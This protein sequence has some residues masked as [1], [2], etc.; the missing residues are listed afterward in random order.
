MAPRRRKFLPAVLVLLTVSLAVASACTRQSDPEPTA[1]AIRSESI[2]V[3]RTPRV[4][5]VSEQTVLWITDTEDLLID[6]SDAETSHPFT[7]AGRTV[8]FPNADGTLAPVLS[9]DRSVLAIPVR[10][11]D[12]SLGVNLV[13][14]DGYNM[15]LHVIGNE[16]LSITSIKFMLEFGLTLLS[17]ND[18]RGDRIIAINN[19][20]IKQFELPISD[21]TGTMKYSP[22]EYRYMVID[23]RPIEQEI[24]LIPFD[25]PGGTTLFSS[26][27]SEDLYRA[28]ALTIADWQ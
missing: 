6:T 3:E 27:Q 12:G 26:S 4:V 16:D 19:Y 8:S 18:E 1:T 7:L 24:E 10:L 9:D 5:T 13:A 17:L 20:G 22:D 14:D 28:I 25:D 2:E 21:S 15:T 23:R 11:S